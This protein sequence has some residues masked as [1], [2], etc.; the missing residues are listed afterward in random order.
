MTLI[1]SQLPMAKITLAAN[2]RFPAFTAFFRLFSLF[3][4]GGGGG[5]PQVQNLKSQIQSCR[6]SHP[7]S[8]VFAVSLRVAF[9]VVGPAWLQTESVRFIEQR[10]NG[11]PSPWG[12]GWGEGDSD[13]AGP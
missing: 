8:S 12:E 13:V 9:R 5:C 2:S 3:F 7:P 10:P 1:F 6:Y 11:S 4:C